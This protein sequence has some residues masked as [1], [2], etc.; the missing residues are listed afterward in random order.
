MTIPTPQTPAGPNWPCP[1]PFGHFLSGFFLFFFFSFLLKRALFSCFRYHKVH[2][3]KCAMRWWI[4]TFTKMYARH[5]YLDLHYFITPKGNLVPISSHFYLRQFPSQ[6]YTTM[7]HLLSASIHLP[8]LTI[9]YKRSHTLCVWL[10]LERVQGSS[11][12]WHIS[13]LHFSSQSNII[14]CCGD[15][16]HSIS[17]I[18]FQ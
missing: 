12:L 8:I 4:T 16:P 17:S 15:I 13:A 7:H 1:H 3:V 14:S 6:P 5:H 9:E 10:H 18:F 2:F 11:V